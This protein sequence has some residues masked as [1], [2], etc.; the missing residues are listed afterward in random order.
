MKAPMKRMLL[1]SVFQNSAWALD[2]LAR[3]RA[4]RRVAFI[5]TASLAEE[6]GIA[7][8]EMEFLRALGLEPVELEVSG[9]SEAQVRSTLEACDL[10]YVSGGNTFF[11]L[12]ELK[13]KGADRMIRELVESGTPYVGE[14][15]GAIVA[16]PDIWY[17]SPMDDP[18]KAPELTG[19]NGLGLVDFYPVPHLDNPFMG[20]AARKIAGIYSGNLDLRILTDNQAIL[21]TGDRA[22]I[23]EKT[24]TN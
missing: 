4:G 5:P 2:R 1:C 11:L 23:L 19:Y 16:A 6:G 12:Q 21:V 3:E 7:S 8:Q 17:S 24:E 20:D 22:E 13:R 15:A 18:S 10:I 14:S 9:C